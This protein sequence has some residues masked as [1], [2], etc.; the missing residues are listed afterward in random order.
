MKIKEIRE[1]DTAALNEELANLQKHLFNLRSQAVTE[2][3]E[4]PS[5][6]GKAKKDIARVKTILRQRQLEEQKKAAAAK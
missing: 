6:L 2:K 1:K 4:N 5:Q 3:L